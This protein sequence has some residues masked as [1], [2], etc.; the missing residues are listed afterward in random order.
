MK[1]YFFTLSS[2]LSLFFA[3]QFVLVEPLNY[4]FGAIFWT[5]VFGCIAVEIAL[6]SIE[7]YIKY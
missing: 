1:M 5:I 3:V 4:K 7:N 2:I 6:K